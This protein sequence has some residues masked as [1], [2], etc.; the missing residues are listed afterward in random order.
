LRPGWGS[1]IAV[2]LILIA[3]S[4]PVYASGGRAMHR[5]KKTVIQGQIVAYLAIPFCLNG[6]GYW[7]ILIRQRMPKDDAAQLIRVELSLP[8]QQVPTWSTAQPPVQKFRLVR[9]QTQDAVLEKPADTKSDSGEEVVYQIPWH[10][11]PGIEP[12][13]LPYGKVL[14]AYEWLDFP[15][16]L[17]L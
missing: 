13:S 16:G 9:E 14:P 10:F 7:Y 5:Q 6:N 17:A 12:F 4:L 2:A 11:P 1:A 3:G 15:P 8:C